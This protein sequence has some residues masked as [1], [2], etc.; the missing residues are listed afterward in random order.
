MDADDNKLRDAN[1][2]LTYTYCVLLY[3]VI[4]GAL[5]TLRGFIERAIP[6][7]EKPTKPEF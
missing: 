2:F 1:G 3:S 5:L 7:K 6:E 4:Y